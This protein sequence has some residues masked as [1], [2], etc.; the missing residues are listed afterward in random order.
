LDFERK[1]NQNVLEAIY[2]NPRTEK[3]R[4]EKEKEKGEKDLIKGCGR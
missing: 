4:E 3:R 2:E 1:L